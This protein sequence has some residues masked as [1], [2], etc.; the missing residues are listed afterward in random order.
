MRRFGRQT[1]IAATSVALVLAAT[2]TSLAAI[3]SA[4]SQGEV[5]RSSPALPAPPRSAGPGTSLP[6]S[7]ELPTVAP[8]DP[9]LV[10]PPA[11]DDPRAAA[12][13]PEGS[14]GDAGPPPAGAGPSPATGSSA[15]ATDI[16]PQV[17]GVFRVP[18]QTPISPTPTTG[19][20]ALTPTTGC[21]SNTGS[22]ALPPSAGVLRAPDLSLPWPGTGPLVLLPQAGVSRPVGVPVTIVSASAGVLAT[23]GSTLTLDRPVPITYTVVAGQEVASGTIQFGPVDATVTVTRQACR[24]RSLVIHDVAGAELDGQPLRIV[25]VV[26]SRGTVTVDEL[27]GIARFRS[28]TTGT[29][30]ISL[31]TANDGGA[32]GPLI[33]ATVTVV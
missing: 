31:V 3:R 9:V 33:T 30:A 24:D 8:Q 2:G 1:A 11:A 5:A 27:G 21:A 17:S 4:R 29:Y 23:D 13:A 28:A 32:A 7:G 18:A 15:P 6:P 22:G 16:A 26:S 25:G 20:V 12:P 19:P 10:A 14:G